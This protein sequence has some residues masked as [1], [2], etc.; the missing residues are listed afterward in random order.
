[1]NFLANSISLKSRQCLPGDLDSGKVKGKIVLCESRSSGAGV[2]MAD[3]VGAIMPGQILND[4]A[5][6]LPLPA[7][8]I[9]REDINKVLEYIRTSKYSN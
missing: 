7:T 3:G 1:M 4:I 6:P 9:S 5:F 8:M 2:I